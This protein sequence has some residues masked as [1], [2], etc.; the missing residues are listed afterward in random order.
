M[1]C[2]DKACIK[3]T[4]HEMDT[5]VAV[6]VTAHNLIE[7]RECPLRGEKGSF[8]ENIKATQQSSMAKIFRRWSLHSTLLVQSI[9]STH[10]F[11]PAGSTFRWQQ[12]SSK[13]W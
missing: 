11:C 1:K 2:L 4:R 12:E 10:E 7:V 8:H 6:D 9:S 5:V 13:T 3:E